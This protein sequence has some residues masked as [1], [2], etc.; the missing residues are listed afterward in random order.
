MSGQQ[1]PWLELPQCSRRRPDRACT[2]GRWAQTGVRGSSLHC[3][4][5]L[6]LLQEERITPFSGSGAAGGCGHTAPGLGSRS[7][8]ACFG[9]LEGGRLLYKAA[10]LRGA[11]RL[12]PPCLWQPFVFH[13]S[14]CQGWESLESPPW[15]RGSDASTPSPC[16]GP[17]APGPLCDQEEA[18]AASPL[19]PKACSALSPLG[20]TAPSRSSGCFLR[21]HP[22]P[23]PLLVS[24]LQPPPSPPSNPGFSLHCGV[25]VW[26]SPAEVG[27]RC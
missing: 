3:G 15:G 26:V 2:Q 12:P 21:P 1:G 8:R 10:C 7:G 16:G 19:L 20:L 13:S 23:S 27:A 18:Q 4:L 17:V 24:H 25:W 14:S 11:C 5:R 9:R 22:V 6:R